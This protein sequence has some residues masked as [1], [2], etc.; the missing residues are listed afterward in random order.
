MALTM[1]KIEQGHV[2]FTPPD[3][4]LE[5][6]MD[7]QGTVSVSRGEG[8]LIGLGT[9]GTAYMAPDELKTLANYLIQIASG[10][11]V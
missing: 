5:I 1:R 4:D 7:V 8:G 10:V 11:D 2:Q 9:I 3:I 6:H